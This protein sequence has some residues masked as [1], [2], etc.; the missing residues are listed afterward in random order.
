M[1]FRP[2]ATGCVKSTHQCH[3]IYT[4]QVVLNLLT[5]AIKFTPNGGRIEVRLSRELGNEEKFSQYP[6][7]NYVQ[8]QVSDTGKGIS[9]DFLPHVFERRVRV[10]VLTFYLTYLSVFAKQIVAI[11]GQ[12]KDWV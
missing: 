9:A 1:P 4:Q 8:I 12:I 11:L 2:L 3:Q 6:I 5:N 10:S 7:P